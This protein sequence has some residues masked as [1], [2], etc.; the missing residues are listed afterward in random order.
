VLDPT[1][2]QLD[3]V[4]LVCGMRP[5]LERLGVHLYEGTPVLGIDEGETI[6]LTVPN[7]RV[8]AKA[9]VLATNAYTPRLGYL[10]SGIVPLHSHLVATEPL[11]PEDISRPIAAA[12]QRACHSQ[13]VARPATR[14]QGVALNKP[15]LPRKA[16]LLHPL[17]LR[18]PP[19]LLAFGSSPWSRTLQNNIQ[20]IQLQQYQFQ[21]A[22]M[23]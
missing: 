8:R 21:Y 1:A 18:N 10:S 3:G 22:F 4:S 5:V 15:L 7:A 6:T 2:G 13:F 12:V 14:G 16:S 23:R 19:E 17:T 9:V 11:T 20:S